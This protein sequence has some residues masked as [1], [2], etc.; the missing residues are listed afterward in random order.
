MLSLESTLDVRSIDEPRG[1]CC[2]ICY[3]P[4]SRDGLFVPRNLSCGH[5]YCTECLV[6][7]VNHGQRG[8]ICCPTCKTTTKIPGLSNDATRLPKNFGVLEILAGEEDKYGRTLGIQ[9]CLACDEHE[10]EPK[11]VYCL[12][13]QEIICIYCQVYGKH[14]GHDC[15]LVKDVAA[16]ERQNLRQLAEALIKHK[17]QLSEVRRGVHEMCTAVRFKEEKLMREISHHFELLRKRLYKRENQ[18]KAQV[19]NQT[20]I[21]VATL[22]KQE[23]ELSDVVSKAE[24]LEGHCHF[25]IQRSDRTVL[26]KKGQV[27][28]TYKQVEELVSECVV[29][30]QAVDT[31]SCKFVGDILDL[32]SDYGYI[33]EP[34][35]EENNKSEVKLNAEAVAILETSSSE[36][37]EGENQQGAKEV[38]ADIMCCRVS[39]QR[40]PADDGSSD[41]AL[42]EIDDPH[43]I[44]ANRP[45]VGTKPRHLHSCRRL[46]NDNSDNYSE[47]QSSCL[48]TSETSSSEDELE[49]VS[50]LEEGRGASALAESPRQQPSHDSQRSTITRITSS[51]NIVIEVTIGQTQTT[52]RQ[53]TSSGQTTQAK[54]EGSNPCRG[55]HKVDP[56]DKP[57]SHVH[58]SRGRE[59]KV[60]SQTSRLLSTVL[61]RRKKHRSPSYASTTSLATAQSSG[62]PKCSVVNCPGP[63]IV[64]CKHC[65]RAFCKEC[66]TNSLSA[67]RC[68]KRPRGHSL[69]HV[70]NFPRPPKVG[71]DNAAFAKSSGTVQSQPLSDA[72]T[73][74]SNDQESVSEK[75][76]AGGAAGK[77]QG[78]QQLQASPLRKWKCLRCAAINRCSSKVCSRCNLPRGAPIP[79]PVPVGNVCPACTL[80]NP[81][82]AL[83]CELCETELLL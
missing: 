64:K 70:D 51:S 35:G 57:A 37:H 18:L 22:E 46:S 15:A 81:M 80:L 5:S 13:D 58:F 76:A 79:E 59:T 77:G 4:F 83:K 53:E 42:S 1:H 66:A 54:G 27:Q 56:W 7:L 17:Q 8:H 36:E 24:E 28:E 65:N 69:I 47:S 19:K 26:E 32:L 73:V 29:H 9:P 31:L 21:R 20:I 16:K 38:L 61:G 44:N 2:A 41:L 34:P 6:K 23:R 71:V 30:P 49:A 40:S 60:K 10:N 78:L 62:K 43:D 48:A 67:K 72:A 14:K 12:S 68:Y 50:D 45:P 3:H 74:G 75:T 25:L 63:A 11:K 33:G 52:D 55:A 82:A 39:R